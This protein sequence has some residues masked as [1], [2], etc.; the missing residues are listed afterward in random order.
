MELLSPNLKSK[1][2]IPPLKK[3]IFLYFGKLNIL[4]LKLKHFLYFLKR[5]F[6]LY[7]EKQTLKKF[8]IF[9][10]MELSYISGNGNHKKLICQEVILLAW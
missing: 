5:K 3:V 4:A 1:K 2:I 9:Q 8:L 6:F 10:E 7:F